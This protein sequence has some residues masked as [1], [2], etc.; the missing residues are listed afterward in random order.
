VEFGIDYFPAFST[1]RQTAQG[2]FADSLRL[3]EVGEANNFSFCKIVEHYFTPYAGYSPDPITFLA[4][5]AARTQRMRVMTGAV[6]PV[7]NHPLHQAGQLAMLDCIS[8]GRLDAGF[9][10]AF[11]PHEFEAFQVSLDESRDR[12]EEG[13]EACVRLWTEESVT[14]KGRFHQFQNITSLPRPVQKPHP[15]IWIAAIATPKSFEWTGTKGYNLMVVPYLIE[16]EHLMECVNTYRSAWRAAGHPGNGGKVMVVLHLNV[17][18]TTA[19]AEAYTKPHMESY[20]ST[21][22]GACRWWEGR[23]SK[24]Y[25]DYSILPK[26]LDAMTYDRVLSENRAIIGDPDRCIERMKKYIDLIGDFNPSF[27]INFADVDFEHSKR[28]MELFHQHVEPEVTK[29]AARAAVA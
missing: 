8:N 4:A 2:Y 22:L 7:F 20:I 23:T 28:S 26:L 12:F 21:F 11:L 5:V 27:Q 15:P 10:R 6:L 13:I 17:A 9:A 1:E 16:P 19:E 3:A 24:D 18:A 25:P 29:L 14:F